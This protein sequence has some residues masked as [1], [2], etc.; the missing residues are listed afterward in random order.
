M[1]NVNSSDFFILVGLVISVDRGIEMLGGLQNGLA[2][3]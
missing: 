3:K 1:V 2:E